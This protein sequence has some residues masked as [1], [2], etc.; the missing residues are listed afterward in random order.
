MELM[1]VCFDEDDFGNTFFKIRGGGKFEE[2]S[3]RANLE[4]FWPWGIAVG[5]F[6]NDG[7]E[8]VFQPAGMGYPFFYWPNYLLMN[9]GDETFTDRTAREGIEP[10]ERFFAHKRIRSKLSARSSRAAAVAD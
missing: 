8:D 1:S 2:M 10:A 7:Y 9:N 6:D 4:T 5:D 3:D